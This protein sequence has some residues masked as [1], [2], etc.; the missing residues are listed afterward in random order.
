MAA[1]KVAA[2][3]GSLARQHAVYRQQAEQQHPLQRQMLDLFFS[4]PEALKTLWDTA[5]MGKVEPVAAF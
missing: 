1:A 3:A 2:E 4:D 5:G